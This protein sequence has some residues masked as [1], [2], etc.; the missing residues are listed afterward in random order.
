MK[1]RVFT[2]PE[3]EVKLCMKKVPTKASEVASLITYKDCYIKEDNQTKKP[4]H[5]SIRKQDLVQKGTLTGIAKVYS[6]KMVK[7]QVVFN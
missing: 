5:N 7:S 4:N 2:G 1:S 6:E 3:V